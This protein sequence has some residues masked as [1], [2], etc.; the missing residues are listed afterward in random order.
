MMKNTQ[1]Q[2]L[3][4]IINTHLNINP[5]NI[6]QVR[7][8]KVGRLSHYIGDLLADLNGDIPPEILEGRIRAACMVGGVNKAFAMRREF[9]RLK[10]E[11]RFEINLICRYSIPSLKRI[12]GEASDIIRDRKHLPLSPFGSH[13]EN[14]KQRIRAIVW[15]RNKA[16]NLRWRMVGRLEG[17]VSA[18]HAI[19][20][21]LQSK[22][23]IHCE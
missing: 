23:W 3:E 8:N 13:D 18:K 5:A 15:T 17:L 10:D 19:R 11:I 20:R 16:Q 7:Q 9:I 14:Y 22:R 1:R 6:D 21:I 2:A 12:V 4:S